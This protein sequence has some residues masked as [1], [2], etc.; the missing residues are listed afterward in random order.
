MGVP[1]RD[2]LRLNQTGH[3]GRARLAVRSRPALGWRAD[4]ALPLLVLVVQIAA[5]VLSSWHHQHRVNLAPLDWLALVAGPIALVE[6]RRHPVGVLCVTFAAT[7]GPS[8]A[9]GAYLSLII[10]FFVA[11]TQGHRQAA[12]TTIV[13]GYVW[14]AW[15]GPLAYGDKV[16][17]AAFALV[18]GAWLVVLVI[19]AEAVRMTRQRRADATAAQ[20]IEA[21]RRASDERLRMAR[22]LH[23]VIGHNISLIN[24]QAGVGLDLWTRRPEQ[25]YEA[26]SAIKA[27]SKEALGELRVMLGALRQDEDEVPRS[28]FPG[29]ARLDELVELTRQAGLGVRIEVVGQPCSL[30]AGVDLAAYRIVQ[31]SLT[32]VARHAPGAEATVR[33]CYEEREVVVEILNGPAS[34]RGGTGG[35][36]T[37]LG[38]AGMRERATALGG[39]F[40]A[41]PQPNGG[42]AIRAHL[43]MGADG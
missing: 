30:P 5:G 34:G 40:S 1:A 3:A 22:E 23:D 6:R 33:V 43:P 35:P 2:E 28:P 11:A 8:G 9:A 24:F 32:N 37:G 20:E 39:Q 14:S 16:A 19:V 25:A 10:A 13:A 12:W 42:F 15:L 41:G 7:L 21:Q 27:V 4:L 17:S 36:G 18:L 29:L 31:E 26:L 38:I